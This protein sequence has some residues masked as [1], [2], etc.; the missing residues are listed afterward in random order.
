MT[1]CTR[2]LKAGVLE[3]LAPGGVQRGGVC[4]RVAAQAMVGPMQ[5]VRLPAHSHRGDVYLGPLGQDSGGT[6]SHRGALGLRVVASMLE[7]SEQLAR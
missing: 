3:G 1:R 2:C 7:G 4:L 6:G 5:S